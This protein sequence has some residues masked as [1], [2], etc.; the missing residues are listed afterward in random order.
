MN[1]LYVF[2]ADGTVIDSQRA[3]VQSQIESL[4]KATGEQ[5]SKL[6]RELSYFGLNNVLNARGI[7]KDYFFNK[8]HKTFDPFE[9]AKNGSIRIFP[10]AI[11]VLPKLDGTKA[12]IS[13]SSIEATEKKIKALDF[14]SYMNYVF[15]EFESG[16]AKPSPYMAE[17]L[18]YEMKKDG[19]FEPNMRILNI[20]DAETDMLFGD[21]L[22]KAF[23]QYE[24]T[25]FL[26]D[27]CGK[28]KGNA[29]A[30]IIKSLGEING[31]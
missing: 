11:E 30:R 12:L 3:V 21:S 8:I 23:P 14:G 18:A 31:I 15:A 6:E 20:G 19:I 25:N 29:N 22:S 5:Y 1:T 9:K 10:D 16:K 13:N 2:D 26:V 24:V 17:K 27:R 28:Y 4:V 7:G